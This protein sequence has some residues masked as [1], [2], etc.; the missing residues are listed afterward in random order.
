[1]ILNLS[2][3]LAKRLKVQPDKSSMKSPV[4]YEEWFGHVFILERKHFILT[5]DGYS[6]FA[7][8]IE[9][10]GIKGS[11]IYV[12]AFLNE[13]IQL[14][15]IYGIR[16][17]LAKVLLSRSESLIIKRSADK[18][19]I[20][21]MNQMIFHAG[22]CLVERGMSRIET[23]LYLNEMPMSVVKGHY[24]PIDRFAGQRLRVTR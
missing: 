22:I 18:S 9:A 2:A 6:K 16:E 3:V 4:P 14:C 20:S 5:V 24:F 11:E 8:I 15:K 7:S 17:Q 12:D 13:I 21:T 19:V 23:A 10:K 1:M